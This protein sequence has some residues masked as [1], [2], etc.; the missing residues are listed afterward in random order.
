M[1]A[2]G[3]YLYD[4]LLPEADAADF[5]TLFSAVADT[6]TTSLIVEDGLTWLPWELV[7]PYQHNAPPRCLVDRYD[8]SRWVDGLGPCCIANLRSARS[9][10]RPTARWA[11]AGPRCLVPCRLQTSAAWRGPK[12]RYMVCICCARWT[13]PSHRRWY[14]WR[15]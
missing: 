13:P 12:A 9:R 15:K 8:L 10:W 7:A 11:L 3:A 4:R 1:Q 6:I 14:L 5:R 2:L